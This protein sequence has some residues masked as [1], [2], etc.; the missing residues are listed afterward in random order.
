MKRNGFLL[1]FMLAEILCFANDGYYEMDGDTLHPI[2][3]A[4]VSMD[5]ERLLISYNY[6][7][8]EYD[9]SAY[10]E[11]YNHE[12]TAVRPLVGFEIYN[13]PAQRDK[14]DFLRY[15]YV[16]RVND[17]PQPFELQVVVG[18]DISPY[19]YTLLYR[20][21]FKPGL[22]RVYHQYKLPGG[23][24]SLEGMC[25]Y[26]LKTGARWKGGV[27]KDFEIIVKSSE[28]GMLRTKGFSDFD[29]A[30]EGKV[31]TGI[32]GARSSN[33]ANQYGGT[34]SVNTGYLHKRIRN[35]RPTQNLLVYFF[36]FHYY[37][38]YYGSDACP[39]I[40]PEFFYFD[41]EEVPFPTHKF[42]YYWKRSLDSFKD[43]LPENDDAEHTYKL[44]EKRV[45]GMDKRQLRI[46]RNTLY[47]LRGRV[48]ADKELQRYFDEQYWYYPNAAQKPEEIILD[49]TSKE[50]LQKI[51]AAERALDKGFTPVAP[52]RNIYR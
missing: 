45:Q 12:D 22:N 18:E 6:D 39:Y 2:D 42:I 44:Y 19:T 5:Y 27:I 25:V 13:S 26:V 37:G 29:V 1:F 16:L 21:E 3:S 20:P 32:F 17:E 9:I 30:G 49:E 28:P 4:N 23:K 24:G 36:P 46:L 10:I 43:T 38:Y 14:E 34:F 40:D 8:N 35:F 41:D 51:I 33:K 48:F 15:G 47:A 50:I 31:F 7:K 11:L 52:K